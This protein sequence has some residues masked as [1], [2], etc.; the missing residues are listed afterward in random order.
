MHGYVVPKA[1]YLNCEIHGPWLGVQ[2]VGWGQH[3]HI[4]NMY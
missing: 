4:V 1:H 3:G 2:A